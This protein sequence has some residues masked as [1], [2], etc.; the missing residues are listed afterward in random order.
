MWKTNTSS[1]RI[2]AV[3]ASTGGP[4]IILELLRDLPE[5]GPGIVIV[6]HLIDGFSSQLAVYLNAKCK[7]EVK[8][9]QDGEIVM[10]GTAYV[11]PSARH[12]T[13]HKTARGYLMRCERGEKVNGFCPSVDKLFFSAAGAG[14]RAL[15]IILSGMGNDGAKGMLAM[16]KAGAHTIAQEKKSCVVASMPQEAIRGG[17]VDEILSIEKIKERILEFSE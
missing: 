12:L 5:D 3:G 16:R 11:A 9:A 17:A 6:Q 1:Y 2:I 7:I 13:V 10:R 14:S 15:G 8:E 4:G